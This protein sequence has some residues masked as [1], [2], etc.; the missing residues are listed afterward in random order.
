VG[1]KLFPTPPEVKSTLRGDEKASK[2]GWRKPAIS[3][4]NRGN[5]H[6]AKIAILQRSRETRHNQ[7]KWHYYE[8]GVNGGKKRTTRCHVSEAF[9]TIKRR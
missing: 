4:A 2:N 9:P 5:S 7:A 8:Y 1:A 6:L 3:L